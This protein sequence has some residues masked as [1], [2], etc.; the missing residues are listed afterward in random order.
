[1]QRRAA[2]CLFNF[3]HSLHTSSTLCNN[4]LSSYLAFSKRYFIECSTIACDAKSV[5]R[6]SF[7]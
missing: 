1:M 7:C 3:V 4:D 6:S 2:A 5:C